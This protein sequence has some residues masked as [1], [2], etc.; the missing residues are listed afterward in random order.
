M[1]NTAPSLFLDSLQEL[2]RA[3]AGRKGMDMADDGM[4]VQID[5]KLAER[6]RTAAR[7]AGVSVETFA[8]DVLQ[9]AVDEDWTEDEARFA[10]FARTGVSYPA[11]TALEEF[12]RKIEQRFANRAE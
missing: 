2:T 11:E 12:R 9:D 8:A 3:G 5:A 10:E 6:L 4:T 1:R 7:S